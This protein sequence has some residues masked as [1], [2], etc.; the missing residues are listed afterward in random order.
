M[1]RIVLLAFEGAQLLDIA[2]PLQVFATT[3]EIAAERELADPYAPTVASPEGGTVAT[4]SGLGIATVPLASLRRT[5]DTVIAA[6]GP[7]T[8]AAVADGRLV[9][10]LATADSRARRICSVCTGAFLL[11]AAGLLDG[12]RA[13][14][15]WRVCGLLQERHP[16]VR[17][18]PDPIFVR[19]GRI[20]TSA[21]VTAG[22]D[23]ALALVEEDLGRALALDVAR[24]LVVF[25]KRPGGQSQFSAMLAAQ[26]AADGD[27][28]AL[29]DWIAHHLDEDLRVERLAEAAAMSPR[30]FARLYHAKMGRT[31]ARAVEAMRLEAARRALEEGDEPISAVARRCGFGDEERM[32]RSFLRR[33]GTG[34]RDYRARFS[35]ASTKADT[36]RASFPAPLPSLSSA[37]P[38]S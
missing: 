32:R 36:S 22:I 8:A 27:F 4:S 13:A 23:L 12:R 26:T 25:L 16:A 24:R 2:G 11:A 35:R 33:L 3:R 34:P 6:G 30:H 10:W 21:G 31:P 28:A 1:R 38:S 37:A 18:E 15:H 7:G 29:H 5:A 20:W 19:D 9:R 14:T 17:V